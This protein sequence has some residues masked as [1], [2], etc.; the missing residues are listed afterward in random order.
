MVNKTRI[1][2]EFCSLVEIDSLS[3]QEREIADII[4]KSLSNLGFTVKEDD[5]GKH[6]SGNCGNIY[7]YLEGELEG[8]PLLFSAH[9]DTVGPGV[10]KKAIVHEDGT[11]TSD[12]STVLGADDL[13]GIVSIL[14]AVRTIKEN[15][16]PHRSIEILFTIAEEVYIRGS[17]VYDY[18]GIRAKEAYV[19]DLS[20]PVGTAALTAPTLVSFTATI[21]GKASHAGFA[22]ELGI[23]AIAVAAKAITQIKQG[24]IDE[25]T[26]VNIGL[27]EGGKARNII[28]DLC[29]L[30]GEVR[31]LH[32]G[33]A[34]SETDKI[35]D[36]IHEVALE[37]HAEEVF[38]TEF[39]CLAYK[40]EQEHPVVRRFE[41]AC[42][43]LGYEFSYIDTFGG[44]DN[45]NFMRYGITGIVVACGMNQVHSCSE[46]THIEELAKCSEI[47]LR[48]MTGNE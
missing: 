46:Y 17:E 45:N 6:Y 26:T 15:G 48:L 35:K 24:R 29:I 14:E 34:L 47:V 3:F 43:E 7:G 40:V 27:I 22:P 2:E 20:G 37:N 21:H 31:S 39:G 33:K 1:T 19:L 41:K 11:I 28:S 10:N 42:A 12:G 16:L 13:S 32:H 4:K 9:L 5:A 18:S 23:N 8:E 44:S 30:K 25:D 36:I 38:E